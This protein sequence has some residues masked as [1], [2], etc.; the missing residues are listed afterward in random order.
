MFLMSFRRL[1]PVTMAVRVFDRRPISFL[2]RISIRTRYLQKSVSII[3]VCF[4]EYCRYEDIVGSRN[5]SV[6]RNSLSSAESLLKDCFSENSSSG[7]LGL[8]LRGRE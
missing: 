7:T 6:L 1:F 5:L 2:G 3:N 4:P 8:G